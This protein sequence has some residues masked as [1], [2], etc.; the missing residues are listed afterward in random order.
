M[1]EQKQILKIRK[2]I[3]IIE[4]IALF[5]SML[6]VLGLIMTIFLAPMMF[7]TSVGYYAWLFG[8]IAAILTAPAIAFIEDL[9]KDSGK[10]EENAE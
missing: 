10:E 8:S 3:N 9:I 5:I 1:K 6:G 2:A 4:N 7:Y